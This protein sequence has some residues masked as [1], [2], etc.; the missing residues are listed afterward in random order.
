MFSLLGPGRSIRF[1][2]SSMLTMDHRRLAAA[3][4]FYILF[5]GHVHSIEFGRGF[6]IQERG[7]WMQA[8]AKHAVRRRCQTLH[9][10]GTDYMDNA[11]TQAHGM[12]VR[13]LECQS[14]DERHASETFAAIVCPGGMD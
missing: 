3:W 7:S 13:V 1:N 9:N 5:L 11:A 14:P 2:D 10:L 12:H 6:P 4:L 8:V